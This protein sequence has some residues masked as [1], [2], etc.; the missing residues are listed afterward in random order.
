MIHAV[1]KLIVTTCNTYSDT[2]ILQ[3]FHATY[4][5]FEPP[6]SIYESVNNTICWNSHGYDMCSFNS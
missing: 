5:L 4:R 2:N 6:G 1:V 3:S